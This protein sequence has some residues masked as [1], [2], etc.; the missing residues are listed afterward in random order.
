MT[1][2]IAILNREAVA[3]AAD[4][5]VT[6][7]GER[8]KVYNS[9]NK[10]FTLS[11]YHPVGIM[12]YGNAR[13]ASVPWETIIKV[14]R[15]EL[16]DKAFSGLEE[17]ASDF[18]AYVTTSVPSYVPPSAQEE[19]VFSI[20]WSYF[21]FIYNRV[22]ERCE[23]IDA[24]EL[25]DHEDAEKLGK[26]ILTDIIKQEAARLS[27][28]EFAPQFDATSVDSILEQY[29]DVIARAREEV[30]GQ[31]LGSK[32]DRELNKL[33]PLVIAKELETPYHSGVVIAGFGSEDIYPKL[34]SY[35]VDG[36]V[37][38]RVKY[39]DDQSQDI[40]DDVSAS[41]TPFAQG[42]M[43]QTFM[44]GIDPSFRENEITWLVGALENL[45]DSTIGDLPKG[46]E[47]IAK[48]LETDLEQKATALLADYRRTFTDYSRDRY[49]APILSVVE[50]MPKEE[51][52]AVAEALVNLTAFKRRVSN[53]TETVGGPIDVAVIS[54]GDG[55]IWIKRKHYFSPELNQ[56]FLANY[57]TKGALP[58]RNEE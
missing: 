58:I 37:L 10:L 45:I 2:E 21:Q 51:L 3:L 43:V 1:A 35:L 31:S 36:V 46:S 49:W 15:E 22:A 33:V 34:Q 17:Y 8:N 38:D 53:E 13:L 11:K 47:K 27:E 9:A 28:F 32:I 14:Y 24:E 39:R 23:Q 42:E 5:A 20:S 57:F 55:F 26:S 40:G 48:G 52:A 41:V 25:A 12:I 56:H 29:R 30:F 7:S 54:K 6:I 4:S 16:G 18:M 44:E 50:V 19:Y